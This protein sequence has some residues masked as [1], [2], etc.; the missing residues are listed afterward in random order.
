MCSTRSARVILLGAVVA[1]A[2]PLLGGCGFQRATNNPRPDRLNDSPLVVDE[3]MQK[4]EFERTSAYYKPPVVVAGPTWLTFRGDEKTEYSDLITD[5]AIFLTNVVFSPYAAV[6]DPQWEAVEF[7]GA[8]VPPTHHAM[9][10][11]PE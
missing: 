11:L 8:T 7:R 6:K 10:P 1:W 2:I 5:P 3:A 9:P 4:R